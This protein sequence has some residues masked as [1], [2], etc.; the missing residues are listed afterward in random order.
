MTDRNLPPCLAAVAASGSPL[1]CDALDIWWAGVRAV[2]PEVVLQE[3]VH[4]EHGELVIAD[5]AFSLAGI[6]R[7]VVV[8]AGKASAAMAC[9]LYGSVLKGLANRYEIQGWI[10]APEGSFV[11]GSAGPIRLHAARPAGINEP[12]AA[13]VAGTEEILRLVAGCQPHDLCLALLSGG[14]SALLAAPIAGIEL[15]DKQAVARRVAAA[16]GNIA[17]LNTVRRALSRVKGGGL[18]AGCRARHLISLIISD[19]L[20]DPLE[21]IASGP[22]VAAAVVEPAEALQV[23]SDLELLG[24]PELRQVVEVLHHQATRPVAR[25]GRG[26]Q[27]CPVSHLVLA[28]NASAVDAAGVRAVELG[29]RYIMQAARGLE[30]DVGPLASTVART[31]KQLSAEEQVD[32]WISGGEPTV[33][34]P[35][36][37]Q[38][39][40]GGRNQQLVLLSMLE[41][42]AVGWPRNRAG[43]RQPLLCLSAGTDGE[44]GPTQAAGAWFD[45]T[46]MAHCQQL[47]LDAKRSAANADAFGLF[48]ATGNIIPAFSTGTNV[49]DLRI[50]LKPLRQLGS[51]S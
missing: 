35:P 44:D 16:G 48:S 36:L 1:L 11:P 33:K 37:P 20:G 6:R 50:A 2:T 5:S 42:E 17:Q 31:L 29:Y 12:T 30:G 7:I 8:G 34:L 40:A 38:R 46:T 15:A 43:Q 39:G 49:C 18:A 9:A 41:L 4:V 24:D 47:S 22:T 26:G 28:N 45:Q 23:L 3:L 13:A 25:Q 14:G 51:S 19:V 10:N 27:A 21:T 32:C